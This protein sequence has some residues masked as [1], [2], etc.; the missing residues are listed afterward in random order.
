MAS[1]AR[2]NVNVP[3]R[4]R[5]MLFNA[6]QD[7][8]WEKKTN[9]QHF[10]ELKQQPV[11]E[12]PQVTIIF[13]PQSKGTLALKARWRDSFF[14]RW[15]RWDR[16]VTARMFS[17]SGIKHTPLCSYVTRISKLTALES[18]VHILF[19]IRKKNKK[20]LFRQLEEIW[21]KTS[22][23]TILTLMCKSLQTW[24]WQSFLL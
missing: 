11:V 23:M 18:S 1:V 5:L 15:P 14:I 22:K 10:S 13:A 8:R 24:P 19:R 17:S 9:V 12:T 20:S 4:F 7:S 2:G 3:A 21:K 6:N 16:W